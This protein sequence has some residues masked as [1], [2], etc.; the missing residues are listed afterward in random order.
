MNLVERVVPG[1]CSRVSLILSGSL[2]IM[3]AI[4]SQELFIAD[5]KEQLGLV[6]FY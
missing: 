1:V 3:A 6:V 4:N 2:A 5:L